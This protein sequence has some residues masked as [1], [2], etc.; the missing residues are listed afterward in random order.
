MRIGPWWLAAMG[1]SGSFGILVYDPLSAKDHDR[2]AS[3]PIE[4]VMPLSRDVRTRRDLGDHLRHVRTVRVANAVVGRDIRNGL[5]IQ[6]SE[7]KLNRICR[8]L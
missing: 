7:L 3:L 4:L 2:I 1:S 8:F 6:A 5:D